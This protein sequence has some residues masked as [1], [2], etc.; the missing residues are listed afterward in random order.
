M[1]ASNSEDNRDPGQDTDNPLP[2]REDV[3]AAQPGHTAEHY[4]PELRVSL[5]DPGFLEFML[6]IGVSLT[7]VEILY[8]GIA[9]SFELLDWMW[10]TDETCWWNPIMENGRRL[11][12]ALMNWL[13]VIFAYLCLPR[14]GQLKFSFRRV[15]VT[16]ACLFGLFF[17]AYCALLL[18]KNFPGSTTGTQPQSFRG[19]D[20]RVEPKQAS[21][22]ATDIY[23][24]QFART[25]YNYSNYPIGSGLGPFYQSFDIEPFR[26]IQMNQTLCDRGFEGNNDLYGL[27]I[28]ISLYLQWL[29]SFLANNFL[30]GTRQ[31]LQKP[32]LIFSLAICL[33]TIISSFV[34]ACVFSI[35]IEIMY[36][37]YWGGY[38]CVFASAPC[39]VR[40]GSETKWIKLDWTTVTLF[41]THAL[42]IYHGVWF[43][44]YAFDQ[45][46]SR[47]PCGT[48]HF[49]FLPILDPGE[50]FWII[51]SCLT[52]LTLP[53]ILLLPATF[54]FVG[55]LLASEVK[56]TIH[57]SATYQ[58]LFPKPPVSDR[59]QPQTTEHNA[60][61]RDSLGLR[62]YLF[63]TR[64]ARAF[65]EI[66]RLPSHSRG[67]IR[68]VTPINVKD[69]R[70]VVFIDHNIFAER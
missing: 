1:P 31:D 3:N 10:C 70:C 26:N 48:Y 9:L 42:M 51:R 14:Y 22:F 55:L 24:T 68:L 5:E 52:S 30:P 45:V 63:I 15:V 40:L 39:Q 36:W 34:K 57:H 11:N 4:E 25:K 27:G 7:F 60:S 41:T 64:R 33:V 32:Y 47:M 37:M 46:F 35:E 21:L 29:S 61:L 66:L 62:V 18:S 20:A 58:T 49:F 12:W 13:P 38:V 65:R 67:G 69:R 50:G 54:P 23:H 53:L 56:Y 19:C 8:G 2:N 43:V 16:G 17:P 59:D 44:W 28:R 6:S